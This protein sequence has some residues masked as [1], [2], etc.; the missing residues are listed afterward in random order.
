[1]KIIIAT[2]L[3]ALA[4]AI[5][6]I[7]YEKLWDKNLDV[8][9]DFDRDVLYEG[10]ENTLREVISNRKY[11]LIPILQVKFS[12]TRTFLFAKQDNTNVTDM[13]YRNE[14]FTVMP[15]QR[16][17]RSYP[18][19]C[20]H[21]GLFRMNR[22]DIICRSI[23]LDKKMINS[24]EHE[25]SVCV[26]PRV[27]DN[28]DVPTAVNQL[29][30]DIEKNI[31][32]NED[33]FTFAGIRDYQP[34]DSMHSI[35]WKVTARLGNLQVNTYN[36]TFSKKVVLLLNV[37]ANAV[38]RA[39]DIIEW[40]IRIAA[41]MA[42]FF[43]TEQIPVA[44]YT[45]GVDEVDKVSPHIEAGADRTHIRTIEMALARLDLKE[46]SADFCKILQE[47]VVASRD[48]VEYLIISNARKKEITDMYE[49][50]KKDGHVIHFIIPEYDNI[51]LEEGLNTKDY[52]GWMVSDENETISDIRGL[53]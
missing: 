12:I 34:Y 44:L 51:G 28:K 1:M 27:I 17:T 23:F 45:N 29:L 52:T 15:F 43:I 36:T 3:A 30:G 33:P 10:E 9:I 38:R 5:I 46:K 13:Y 53:Y 50:L 20:I 24:L 32:I 48:A 21:R 19:R 7:V 39:Q 6:R 18:F 47:N 49:R 37:E 8:T 22:M 2:A 35:N 16:I 42:S 26:L 40:A 41:H 11:L 4:L 14:F 25:A 31:H